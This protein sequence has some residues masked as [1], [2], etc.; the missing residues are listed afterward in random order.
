MGSKKNFKKSST[1]G[2]GDTGMSGASTSQAKPPPSKPAFVEIPANLS[3]LSI[4]QLKNLLQELNLP[5]DCIEKKDLIDRIEQFKAAKSNSG[6]RP[7]ESQGGAKPPTGSEKTRQQPKGSTASFSS[8]IP[9]ETTVS[10]K[11]ISVGNPEVGKSCLIKRYC[12]GRFV[13]RYIST[14][15]IDYGV[16]KMN[17]Q[18]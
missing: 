2:F 11:I 1:K 10:F 6:S 3:K 9:K 13:K 14:I 8:S 17:I 5:Q 4:K 18:D 15:G 12:E 16:K 7:S